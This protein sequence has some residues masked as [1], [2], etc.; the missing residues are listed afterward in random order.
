MSEKLYIADAL[1]PQYDGNDVEKYLK[2]T[3]D[4]LFLLR[5]GLMW[6]LRNISQD[7]F[8]KYAFDSMSNSIREPVY[9]RINDVEQGLST[10]INVTAQ[11]LSSYIESADGRF[12]TLEAT[13]DGLSSTVYDPDTGLSYVRQ[14]AEGLATRVTSIEGDIADLSITADGLTARVA[15]TEGDIADLELTAQGLSS[16][17]SDAEGNISSVSQT[18]NKINWIVQSGTS[19]SNF[20]MT[21][22]AISLVADNIDLTGFVTFTDLSTPGSTTIS[23]S[24]ITTGTISA[25]RLNL[26]DYSTTTQVQSLISSEVNGLSLSVTNGTDSSTIKLKSGSIE[27]SSQTVK[28][29]GDII[30]ATNLTD[31]TTTISGNNIKTGTISASR[32]DLSGV[33]SISDLSN[34]TT[35]INGSCIKTGTIDADRLNLTGYLKATDV[36]SGGTTTI[37]GDRITTGS[38]SADRVHLYNKMNVYNGASSSTIGGYI[39]Y[40]TSNLDGTSAI[41]VFSTGSYLGEAVASQ[42]GAHISYGRFGSN[43]TSTSSQAFASSGNAG[44]IAKEINITS[45][46]SGGSINGSSV[47]GISFSS[48]DASVDISTSNAN[49]KVW[50]HSGKDS[51]NIPY[52]EVETSNS[53]ASISYYWDKSSDS[54]RSQITTYSGACT[55]SAK[56]VELVSEHENGTVRL[57]HVHGTGNGWSV[58]WCGGGSGVNFAPDTAYASLGVSSDGTSVDGVTLYRWQNG[59]FKNVYNSSGSIT[60]SDERVKYDISY[61]LSK[62]D[63]LIDSLKPSTFKYKDG[64][65]GRTH[66][67][68]I[69]QDL[70]EAMETGGLETTDFA[71]YVY[72]TDSGECGIRYE[73]IIPLLIGYV[74]KLN[75]RIKVLEGV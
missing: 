68:L 34:G 42:N 72:N 44:L 4:Y 48:S 16:R 15:N 5:E 18:A 20:T 32:L 40:A 74:Q 62:Y 11:G 12:S 52:G 26:T 50:I 49:S 10:D 70:L 24:N 37:S 71:G 38:I 35:T 66:A 13:A 7:N 55:A 65:S 6:S 45:K 23:G 58:H 27:I 36:G 14:T 31:G 25:S 19:A 51:S 53:G 64:E 73:E 57:K 69:A 2:Q 33:A 60:S 54:T 9:I 39:G 8:N 41:G 21:D 30:F 63:Y 56:T 46:W 29:T 75:K 43:E 47:G 61:D 22:R 3:N 59:Y 67:G 17:V 28:F 1:F